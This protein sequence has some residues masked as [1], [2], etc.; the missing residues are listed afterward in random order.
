MTKE[1]IDKLES[2]FQFK[3]PILKGIFFLPNN[4]YKGNTRGA[5]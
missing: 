5:S 3:H 4:K 1:N 2:A